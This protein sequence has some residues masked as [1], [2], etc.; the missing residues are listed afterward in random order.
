MSDD[1]DVQGGEPR[2]RVPESAERLRQ[3]LDRVLGSGRDPLQMLAELLASERREEASVALLDL[4]GQAIDGFELKRLLGYGGMGATYLAQS[5]EGPLVAFKV[6]MAERDRARAR[7]ESEAKVLATLQHPNIAAYLSHGMRSD[8]LGWLAMELIEGQSLEATFQELAT[9]RPAGPIARALAEGCRTP[10]LEDD[11]W[12]RRF[13]RLMIGIVEALEHAHERGV[14]HRD[15]KPQ[16]I[17]V[18][19]DLSAALV[20]FGIARDVFR[21]VSL[22][23]A[24][25]R[26]G[27]PG[28]MAPEQ[29]AGRLKELGPRTDLFALGLVLWRGLFGSDLFSSE[30][31]LVRYAGRSRALLPSSAQ[32]LGPPLLGVLYR[33]LEPLAKHRYPSARALGEDLRRLLSDRPVTAHAPGILARFS[34]STIGRRLFLVGGGTSLFGAGFLTARAREPYRLTVDAVNRGGFFWLGDDESQKRSLPHDPLEIEPGVYTLHYHYPETIHPKRYEQLSPFPVHRVSREIEIEPGARKDHRVTLLTIGADQLG[35]AGNWLGT[36]NRPHMPP[37]EE[38]PPR[39]RPY[40]LLR[41]GTGLGDASFEVGVAGSHEPRWHFAPGYH[42]VPAG[43]GY[44]VRATGPRGEQEMVERVQCLPFERTEIVL[45]SSQSLPPDENHLSFTW[46]SVFSPLPSGLELDL[47]DG[48]GRWLNGQQEPQAPD[49]EFFIRCV[50]APLVRDRAITARLL[51]TM[52]NPRRFRRLRICSNAEWRNQ[53]AEVRTT[54]ELDDG[55]SGEFA[56]QL[57]GRGDMSQHV[58]PV[59]ITAGPEGATR[60]TLSI[61]ASVRRLPQDFSSVEIFSG[62]LGPADGRRHVNGH[63]ALSIAAELMP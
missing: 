59:E 44:W 52:P 8:G 41:L 53:D 32:Q 12:R 2:E 54:W 30:E 14:V 47:D 61:A 7:F 11:A 34:R 42:W 3:R 55:T 9:E 5:P 6:M 56:S 28:Y 50:L 63:V 4:S 39:D 43:Q 38:E 17:L 33:A 26:L 49:Q 23:R 21:P 60:C 57:N 20:D 58:V 45:L 29:L 18:R 27:T 19:P 35:P 37:G 16:N 10:L 15:V 48:W 40:S 46:G 22:T 25:M 24:G 62:M 31:E 1:A 51:L 36:A 13:L